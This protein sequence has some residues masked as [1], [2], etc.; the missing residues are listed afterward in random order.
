MQSLTH[1]QKDYLD[2]I[3]NEVNHM[4][5][6]PLKRKLRGVPAD[7]V[8]F[9]SECLVFDPANRKSAKVLLTHPAF[10]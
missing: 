6:R 5:K 9:V 1:T 8:D 7:L 10:R 2:Q 3:C 4:Q